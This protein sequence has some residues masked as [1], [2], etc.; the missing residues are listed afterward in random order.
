VCKA[1]GDLHSQ[2]LYCFLVHNEAFYGAEAL[3]GAEGLYSACDEILTL[4][5]F[6]WYLRP[7]D[8]NRYLSKED[9]VSMSQ[10]LCTCPRHYVYV[11]GTVTM[12]Q[13]Q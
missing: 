9:T 11:P 10:A 6:L 2:S 12:S 13:A 4:D 5:L 8:P 3:Y 7:H 1:Q